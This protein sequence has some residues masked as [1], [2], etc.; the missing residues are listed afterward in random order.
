M[1]LNAIVK[2]QNI[3]SFLEFIKLHRKLNTSRHR[4]HH[5]AGNQTNG[6]LLFLCP[7]TGRKEVTPHHATMPAL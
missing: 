3:D 2:K 7:D 1:N 5:R 4:R 6:S